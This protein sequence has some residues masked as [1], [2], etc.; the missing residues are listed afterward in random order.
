VKALMTY[1]IPQKRMNRF[2][3]GYPV[4]QY[5]ILGWRRQS[6]QRLGFSVFNQAV[7]T[8]PGNLQGFPQPA[9]RNSC[10]P[11]SLGQFSINQSYFEIP[12]SLFS[13]HQPTAWLELIRPQATP[14]KSFEGLSYSCPTRPEPAATDH[15]ICKDRSS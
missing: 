5:F 13:D 6:C 2:Q 15:E 1:F 3:L 9:E 11:E 12:G 8:L 14:L 10:F 4:V 7:Q